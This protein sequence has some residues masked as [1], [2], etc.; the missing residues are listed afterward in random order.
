MSILEGEI[1]NFI[2]T[3]FAVEKTVLDYVK[4]IVETTT[5]FGIFSK[6]SYTYEMYLGDGKILVGETH[7]M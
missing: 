4:R 5:Y 7:S 6:R 3:N 2:T 1:M